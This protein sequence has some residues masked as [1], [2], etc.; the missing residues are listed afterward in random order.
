MKKL[1]ISKRYTLENYNNIFKELKETYNKSL[2]EENNDILNWTTSINGTDAL[3]LIELKDLEEDYFVDKFLNYILKEFHNLIKYN[4]KY[5]NSKKLDNLSYLTTDTNFEYEKE[6]TIFIYNNKVNSGDRI[7]DGIYGTIEI[8]LKNYIITYNKL[9]IE[10]IN[11]I[12][13]EINTRH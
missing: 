6:D 10:K 7:Y 13:N 3:L 12:K 4:S 2:E 11:E 8:D 9:D 5:Y 1:P